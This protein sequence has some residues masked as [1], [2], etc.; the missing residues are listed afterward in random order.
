MLEKITK[1][2][3]LYPIPLPLKRDHLSHLALADPE[4]R[5]PA[6]IDLLLGAE[7]FTSILPHFQRTGLRGTPS[8]IVRAPIDS[9]R[10]F[11]GYNHCALRS[12]SIQ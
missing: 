11:T 1:D 12:K 2:L 10:L 8:A 9:L 7:V 6:S 3:P 4:F 5:S